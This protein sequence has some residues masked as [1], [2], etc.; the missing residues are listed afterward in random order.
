[1]EVKINRQ[2]LLLD[3]WDQVHAKE[4]S[5][6]VRRLNPYDGISCIGLMVSWS[7]NNNGTL[8]DR[9]HWAPM[10]HGPMLH[11]LCDIYFQFYPSPYPYVDP[12]TNKC[13]SCLSPTLLT[14]QDYQLQEAKDHLDQF[15]YQFNKLAVWI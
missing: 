1:M 11:D 10:F 3:E 8:S 15:I 13:Y 12:N 6:W 4:P 14:F 2:K 9:F 5:N 7:C